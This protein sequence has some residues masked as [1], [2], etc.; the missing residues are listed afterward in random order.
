M[1]A[2]DLNRTARI[3]LRINNSRLSK[4]LEGVL[5]DAFGDTLRV[6]DPAQHAAPHFV[7]A[8]SQA[9]EGQ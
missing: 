7:N 8:V 3:V 4:R 1:V 6:I 2:H 9:Y 5:R